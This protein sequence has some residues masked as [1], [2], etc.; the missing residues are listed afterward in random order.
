V[1]KVYVLARDDEGT[2]YLV[3]CDL[4]TAKA[5]CAHGG[6]SRILGSVK[7]T[8]G[9]AQRELELKCGSILM[10]HRILGSVSASSSYWELAASLP[11]EAVMAQFEENAR[12]VQAL[13][14]QRA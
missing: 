8:K 14:G 4:R 5:I 10:Q 3:F 2:G 7:V 1:N 6:A 11:G 12:T 9:M 13:M